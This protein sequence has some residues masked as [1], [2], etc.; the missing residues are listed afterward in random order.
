MCGSINVF[1]S[2]TSSS[3]K[4]QV[5]YNLG[6]VISY[7]IIGGLFGLLGSVISINT[8]VQGILTFII[9]FMMLILGLSMVNFLP[10]I[11]YKLIPRFSFLK[12]KKAN[13]P[14]LI[15][16][17]NGLMPCG[18]LQTMQL[19]ALTTGSFVRGAVSMF[20]FALG[21]VPLMLGVGEILRKLKVKFGYIMHKISASLIIFL[22]VLM[23][24]RSFNYWGFTFDKLIYSSYKD[25]LI[26]E[27]KDD[28]QYIETDLKDFKYKDILVQKGV[29]VK[30][31][32]KVD[33]YKMYGCI[34]S[35]LIPSKDIKYDLKNGDNIIEFTYDE[36]GTYK[37]T[38]WMGM[39]SAN[40]KVVDNLE[41]IKE[42]LNE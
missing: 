27:E 25:Y 31:N 10:K 18:P 41:E 22:S 26:A 20:F 1:V 8:K 30:F 9:S 39:V 36:V 33:N 11:F 28:V 42:A 21:T 40:I 19:Y 29:L 5:I 4:D 35:I 24:I 15:G 38:C 37:Y 14:F 12:I 2:S 6:R 16:L 17:L 23:M 7:T 13:T 3:F 32:I 34:N